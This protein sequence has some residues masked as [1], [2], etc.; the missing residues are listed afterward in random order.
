MP[1][2]KPVV[3]LDVPLGPT[4]QRQRKGLFVRHK[5]N[6][7]HFWFILILLSTIKVGMVSESQNIDSNKTFGISCSC[8]FFNTCSYWKVFPTRDPKPDSLTQIRCIPSEY[9]WS[10][11]SFA[12]IRPPSY[13]IFYFQCTGRACYS[14]QTCG[15]PHVLSDFSFL[16]GYF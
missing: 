1:N 16:V 13:L 6:C 11:G 2:H 10:P 9:A 3:L 12:P 5:T 15:L 4:L 14:C 7:S 8:A